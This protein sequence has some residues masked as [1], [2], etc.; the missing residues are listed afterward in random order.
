MPKENDFFIINYVHMNHIF[1]I[2]QVTQDGLNSDGSTEFS[3]HCSQQIQ[4]KY[5]G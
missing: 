3:I 1:R 4:K 5:A 2:N